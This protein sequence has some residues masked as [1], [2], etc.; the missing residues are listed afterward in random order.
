MAQAQDLAAREPKRFEVGS[1]GWVTARFTA[2]EP[3]PK[4]IWE[5][6]LAESYEVALGAGGAGK[7]TQQSESV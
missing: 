2:D 3:M 4:R 7:R 1:T 5:K 6:W